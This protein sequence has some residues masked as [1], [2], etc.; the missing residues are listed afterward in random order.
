MK[1]PSQLCVVPA[2]Q[3][4]TRCH[5]AMSV[6]PDLPLRAPPTRVVV[7]Q[8]PPA[9]SSAG[10]GRPVSILLAGVYAIPHYQS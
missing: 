2:K 5:P 10:L 6:R 3:A 8:N 7:R 9:G 4:T 1:L